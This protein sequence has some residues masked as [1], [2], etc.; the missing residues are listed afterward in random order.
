MYGRRTGVGVVTKG[1]D[2]EHTTPLTSHPPDRPRLDSDTYLRE[3]S[4]DRGVTRGG[5]EWKSRRGRTPNRGRDTGPLPLLGTHVER[6]RRTGGMSRVTWLNN[7]R[8][9]NLERT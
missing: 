2:R 1:K 9:T 3:N 8:P 6:T 5:Y 4:I 7:E